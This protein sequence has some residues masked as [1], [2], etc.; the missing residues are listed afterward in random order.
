[1]IKILNLFKIIFVIIGSIVGAGFASGA[2]IYL[3]FNSYGYNGFFGIFLCGII[4]SFIIFLVLK[5]TYEN[6]INNYY[7]FL[8]FKIKNKLII[9][10]INNIVN[11][12]L[13]TSFFVMVSGIIFL[14]KKINLNNYFIYFLFILILYFSLIKNLDGLIKINK[15]LIPILIIFIVFFYHKLNIYINN[16][17]ILNINYKKNW[18]LSSFLYSSYNCV[19]LIPLLISLKKEINNKKQIKY[20]SFFS[21]FF[22]IFLAFIIYKLNFILGDNI[23]T[24]EM[25]LL[26]VSTKLGI[27]YEYLYGII[28]FFAIFTST[29]S[30]GYAFL[31]NI[32]KNNKQYKFLCIIICIFSIFIS[33][34][35]F[36]NL[37]NNLYPFF[38][39]LGIIQIM[40]IFL[41]NK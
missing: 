31:N 16:N 26:Y 18:I 41:K 5:I 11:I 15:I 28:I 7:D 33:S 17:F 23:N 22:I 34:F 20:I 1:M 30:S 14:F 32:S 21:G 19:L 40:L 4:T 24:F 13:L 25:P 27:L 3:F 8:T 2:E 9:N 29:V 37:V 6:N 39:Y 38:G 10:I 36:S 35:G 12:F